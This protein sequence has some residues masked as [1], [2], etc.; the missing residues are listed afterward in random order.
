MSQR[1]RTRMSVSKALHTLALLS[2]ARRIGFRR[3]RKL[4]L[5]AATGYIDEQRRRSHRR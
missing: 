5:L 4:L 3:G 1:N 2:V